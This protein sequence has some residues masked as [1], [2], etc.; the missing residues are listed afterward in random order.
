MAT[1]D[2]FSLCYLLGPATVSPKYPAVR[3]LIKNIF[4]IKNLLHVTA[5]K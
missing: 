3:V 5:S 4:W 1:D 2:P